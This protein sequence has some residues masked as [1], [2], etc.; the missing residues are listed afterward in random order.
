M[1]ER[2]V[3]IFRVEEGNL[4]ALP[5]QVILSVYDNVTQLLCSFD[6][7]SCCFAYQHGRV[8]CTP[9]G[10][11]ALRSGVNI[12]DSQKEG[13]TY[14]QRMEKWDDRGFSIAL[15]GLIEE[16]VS[17]HVREAHY[18]AL[19]NRLLLKADRPNVVALQ[20]HGQ[21]DEARTRDT[22]AQR[23]TVL[24]GFESTWA[25]YVRVF[26]LIAQGRRFVAVAWPGGSLPSNLAEYHTL[27]P[28]P[29]IVRQCRLRAKP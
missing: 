7:D 18:F 11:R 16:R 3:T 13:P 12:W 2:L 24:K 5:I 8:L 27:I 19:P 15:P 4:A 10:L 26:V 25:N 28:E 29:S 9:R 20:A 14:S 23:C 21:G 17:R 6:I 1:T 22:L